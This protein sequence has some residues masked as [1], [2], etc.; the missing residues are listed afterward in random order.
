MITTKKE[1][2]KPLMQVFELRQ[3]PQLLVGSGTNGSRSP[4]GDP[5]NWNWE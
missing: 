1:Y 4:Y 2:E 3:Q 5:E